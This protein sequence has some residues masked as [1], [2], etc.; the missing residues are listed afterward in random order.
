MNLL[1]TNAPGHDVLMMGNEAIARGAV[2]AGVHVCAAY[3]GN[4]SSDI[5]QALSE[6]ALDLG[7]HVEW[8][9]NEKV[10]LEVAAAA[11]LTGLRGLAA[12]KQNGLNVAS[13][14]LL[15]LNLT[16]QDGALVV[17]VCDDP[18]GISSSNEQDSR[19]FARMGDLP[20]FEPSNFQ[21]AK[22]MVVAAFQLSEELE[23]PCIVH[24]VTRVSHARGNVRLGPLPEGERRPRFDLSRRYIAPPQIVECHA[25]LRAKLSSCRDR[26]EGSRFNAYEGPDAPELLLVTT[27]SGFMY[28]REAVRM[29]E[30]SHRVGLLK[31]GTTWPL[32]ENIL[33]HRLESTRHVLFVEEGGAF[34]EGGVREVWAQRGG[35]GHAVQFM[36]QASG[37]LPE[38]GE[39]T[40]D[41]V[42]Q[43]LVHW[44]DA[45]YE[46]RP[47]HY[48]EAAQEAV[49]KYAPV[50]ALGF[51]AGCP[52]RATY[53]AVKKALA[54][55]GRDGVLLGDIGCYAL[56]MGPAGF[57]QLKTVHAMGS[58]AGLASG[59]GILQSFGFD[60]P[61]LAL[62]GDS[63]FF[64]AAIPALINAR[65]QGADFLFMIL[66][67]SATAM[68]GFQPHPGLEIR[69]DGTPGPAIAIEDLCR[70]IGLETHMG[71]PFDLDATTEK[72]L[73]LI[74]P[75]AGC[76]VLILKRSCALVRAKNGPPDFR[77]RIKED[78]CLGDAC[79]CNRLCT[80]VF[81]CPGLNWDAEKGKAAIDE[82][83]CAGCGVC[84]Q[85][86]PAGAIVREPWET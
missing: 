35:A 40:P 11:A 43:C 41:L 7:I 6:V 61:V 47:V 56:G 51:C 31:I 27:G 70:T 32:P 21:E 5:V 76:Q 72:I 83:I 53:W 67:N 63:T 10:A 68:T 66:D 64:H 1:T 23:I 57:F 71:D 85:I 73:D 55:D 58:G 38:V 33:L 60:Q 28:A 52:H 36:G 65:H 26:F 37:H 29:L 79:G 24:S 44:F 13:D 46:P 62:C 81:K 77:M 45:V 49:E 15:N 4:P 30:L 18:G 12:M 39:L 59:M 14:F 3:P 17:V 69:A 20:L 8:S 74:R 22:A 2:E 25:R 50:R 42:I 82:A 48:A 16:G 9:V 34:L 80:R 78:A 84:T 19:L 86:C 75:G 54:L